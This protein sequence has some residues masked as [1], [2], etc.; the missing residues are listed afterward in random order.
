MDNSEDAE[1]PAAFKLLLRAGIDELQTQ[2]VHLERSNAELAEAL[3]VTPEDPDFRDAINENTVVIS[4][5]RDKVA[6][7]EEQL[8]RVDAAFR[9]QKA[10]E[11]RGMLVRPLDEATLAQVM[12]AEAAEA[13]AV[14]VAVPVEEPLAGRPGLYL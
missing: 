4:R 14:S 1:D 2:I 8:Y 10:A 6:E 7:L 12:A 11:Q 13:V 9:Q 5:K 3:T